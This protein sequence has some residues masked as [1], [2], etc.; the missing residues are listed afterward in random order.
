MT[1]SGPRVRGWTD[2]WRAPALVAV[3]AALVFLPSLF[4]GFVWDDHRFIAEN[5]S[6]VHPTSWLR[7]L[8]DAH[9]IDTLGAHG[10]V[11]PLRTLEFAVDYALFGDSPFAFHLHSL[12]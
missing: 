4:G 1:G 3:A 2:T 6:V 5:P 8:T 11:R 10:I 7:F 9:T 12:L